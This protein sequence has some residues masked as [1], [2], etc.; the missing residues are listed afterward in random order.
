MD[1][2]KVVGVIVLILLLWLNYENTR[3]SWLKHDV[4]RLKEEINKLKNKK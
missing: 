2:I 4:N 1:D 3:I